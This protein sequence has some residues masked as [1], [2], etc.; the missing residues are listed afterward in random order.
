[1]AFKQKSGSPFQR[2]FGIGSSPIK[3]YNGPEGSQSRADHKPNHPHEGVGEKFGGHEGRPGTWVSEDK[4]VADQPLPMKSPLEHRVTSYDSGDNRAK[5]HNMDYESN[6]KHD[7]DMHGKKRRE[8]IEKGTENKQGKTRKE[9]PDFWTSKTL[10]PVLPMKSSH[11][12][13]I[14]YH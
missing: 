9:S 8:E 4:F 1:M 3:N 5:R 11:H 14:D 7:E 6:P 10:D 2:N 13:L 12:L